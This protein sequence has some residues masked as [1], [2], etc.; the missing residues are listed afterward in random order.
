MVF[1]DNILIL[2]ATM[3]KPNNK[4]NHLTGNIMTDITGANFDCKVYSNVNSDGKAW[5]NSI[6][7]AEAQIGKGTSTPTRQD[8]T[9]ENP[10]TNGGAED[11]R[12]TSLEASYVN[13]TELIEMSTSIVAG[14]AGTITEICKFVVINDS[15]GVDHTI[16]VSRDLLVVPVGFI[17]GQIINVL[18]QVST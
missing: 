16:L 9:I 6:V 18:N 2:L 13:G 17:G 4:N 1:T 8:V 12:N 10:F 3:C 15:N 5:N 7:L 11:N 14:G